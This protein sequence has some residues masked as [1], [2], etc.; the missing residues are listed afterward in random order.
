MSWRNATST[1]LALAIALLALAGA[2][3]GQDSGVGEIKI[4]ETLFVEKLECIPANEHSAVDITAEVAP[5]MRVELYFRRL[6]PEGS[7]YYVGS[8]PAG[9]DQLWATLPKPTEAISSSTRETP[10]CPS[11]GSS[12]LSY[13][14]VGSL[15]F[16]NSFSR[17]FLPSS[18]ASSF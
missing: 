12:R 16:R 7:F 8:V 3:W 2:G 11:T 6:H 10:K 9:G 13:F 4:A 14:L 5:S 1:G 15:C 17:S 18:T